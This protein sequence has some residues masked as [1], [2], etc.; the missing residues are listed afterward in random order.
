M[1]KTDQKMIFTRMARV[2]GALYSSYF[3]TS[4]KKT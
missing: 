3:F 4:E 1:S 2:R